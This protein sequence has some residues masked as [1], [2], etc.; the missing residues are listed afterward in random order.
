MH[1]MDVGG[2]TAPGTDQAPLIQQDVPAAAHSL[3]D[4]P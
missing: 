2:D 1:I 3:S 4:F